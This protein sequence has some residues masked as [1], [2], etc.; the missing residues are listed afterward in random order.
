MPP[1]SDRLIGTVLD[2]R[3]RILRQVGRGGAGIVYEAE[4][5]AMARRVAV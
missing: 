3:Y 4:H 1:A 5:E 2:Q